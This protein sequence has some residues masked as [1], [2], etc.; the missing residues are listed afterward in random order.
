MARTRTAMAA[1]PL[2]FDSCS[3]YEPEYRCIIWFHHRVV[4][5]QAVDVAAMGDVVMVVGGSNATFAC[6]VTITKSVAILGDTENRPEFDCNGSGRAL[7]FVGAAVNI[8]GLTIRNGNVSGF[9][10]GVLIENATS[11]TMTNCLFYRNSATF[12]GAI[13]IN[14]VLGCRSSECSVTVVV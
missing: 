5:Q 1:R 7:L 4:V 2:H 3:R 8:S 12:G 13:G 9:G 6:G 14:T 10:G 11:V